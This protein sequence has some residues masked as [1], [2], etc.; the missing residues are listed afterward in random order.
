MHRSVALAVLSL[1]GPAAAETCAPGTLVHIVAS[2]VMPGLDAAS[3]EARPKHIFRIGDDRI[4]VEEALDAANGIQEVV[5]I[6]EPDSWMAN[7]HAGAGRHIVDAGPSFVAKAPVFGLKDVPARLL[8]LELGC[9]AAFIAAYAPSPV[10]TE[11][12]AGRRYDV[13]RVEADGD[14]VEVLEPAGTATPAFARY[15]HAGKLAAAIRYDLYQTGLP[16]DPSLFVPPAGVRY[17]EASG[18]P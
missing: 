3:F 8:E 6:A 5:V 18:A 4:R 7:L 11:R 13:H 9:E 14:A 17:E 10:R 12:I 15:D 16:D 1:C 2:N